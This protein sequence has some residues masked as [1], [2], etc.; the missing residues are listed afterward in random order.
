MNEFLVCSLNRRIYLRERIKIHIH[1]SCATRDIFAFNWNE[2]ID[3]N[4]YVA[5]NTILSSIAK[6]LALSNREEVE[7][8]YQTTYLGRMV[9]CD[10]EKKTFQLLSEEADFLI[11]D[12]IDER[13]DMIRARREDEEYIFTAASQLISNHE[14]MEKLFKDFEI[15][16]IRCNEW[17]EEKLEEGIQEYARRIG[18]C[19]N[20]SRIIL[21]KAYFV[22]QYLDR[23]KNKKLFTTRFQKLYMGQLNKKLEYM[24]DLFEKYIPECM[25]IA[26]DK[27]YYADENHRWGCAPMHY[28][29]EYYH[30][31]Y[32]QILECIRNYKEDDNHES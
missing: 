25:V 27:K 3:V 29:E 26:A 16:Y 32:N 31:L 15:T 18:D 28:E 23:E 12:L 21:H 2:K 10:L 19:I 14:F 13:L 9:L 1:G 8:E 5:R 11:I 24:Y 20:K 6:P 7:K 17:Q 30:Y 22:D 4:T